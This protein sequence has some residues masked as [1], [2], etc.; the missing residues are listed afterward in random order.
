[1]F[2][3]GFWMVKIDDSSCN[4]NWKNALQYPVYYSTQNRRATDNPFEDPFGCFIL[5][6]QE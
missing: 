2:L 3:K 4:L 6:M 1:M 5:R